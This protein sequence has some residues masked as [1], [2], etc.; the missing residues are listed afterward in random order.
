MGAVDLAQ[1][2]LTTFLLCRAQRSRLGSRWSTKSSK[3]VRV[4]RPICRRNSLNRGMPRSRSR[5][6]SSATISSFPLGESRC[7]MSQVLQKQRMVLQ[8]QQTQPLATHAESPVGRV[9]LRISLAAGPHGIDHRHLGL[10]RVGIVRNCEIQSDPGPV[11]AAD[12]RS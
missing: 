9:P 8:V 1:I 5:M 11:D 4:F 6:M 3:L 12:R 2:A 10:N 7:G